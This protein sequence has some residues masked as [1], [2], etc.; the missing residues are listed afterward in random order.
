MSEE[1]VVST[2]ET[3]ESVRVQGIHNSSGDVYYPVSPVTQLHGRR[4]IKTNEPLITEK[5]VLQVLNDALSIHTK[6]RAEE[7]YLEKYVRGVQPILNRVKVYHTEINNK[8]VVNIANQIVAFKMAEFAGEPIQ[9]VSRGSKKSI[10]K[11]VEKLNS[12]MLT[13]CKPTKDMELATKMFTCGVGYRLILRDKASDVAKGD[14]LD[15]APFEIYTP[16]PW[17]T[18][19]I[20]LNNVTKRVVAGVTYVYLTD[21]KCLYTVYTPNVT[22]E[23]EGTGNHADTIKKVTQHNF[24]AVTLIEYPC[25]ALYMS[26]IEVVHDMLNAISLVQSNRLDGIEQFI[27]ALMVFE[28]VDASREQI[29]EMKDMGAIKLPPSMDGRQSKVYYLNEQLDQTQTQT[30]VDDMYNTVLQIVGVPSQGDGSTSDSS[31]NGAMIIKNGWWNAEARTLEAEGMWKQAETQL[32]KIVL[33][34]CDEANALSGLKVS[35][36]EPKFSRRSYEA[37]LV[38]TQSFATLR[39][40]GCTSLQAFKYSKLSTD[41]ESDAIEFD[42]YQEE[43]ARKLDEAANV[44]VDVTDEDTGEEVDATAGTAAEGGSGHPDSSYGVCPICH[45]TF[46][47]KANNQ[48]YD[49]AEC[50]R[51]A[52]SRK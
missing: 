34:I 11:R 48:K 31:N 14:L 8:V 7:V 35:D 4:E 3:T 51:I 25:N 43:E 15:E 36:V 1:N 49:R 33:K 44:D 26:P 27:Q 17:N 50:R 39:S 52:A 22:Y 45:R 40:A 30:L 19:V 47:K 12:M 42:E 5:N 29:M 37:L 2:T 23:I 21:E 16:D 41:P 6:N 10:P 20:K 18:F 28:G 38:K 13:E 46:K 9:Y 32:L 24:G